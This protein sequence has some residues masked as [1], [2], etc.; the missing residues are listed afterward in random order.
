MSPYSNFHIY[1]SVENCVMNK[2]SLLHDKICALSGSAADAQTIAEIVNYQLDVHI[3]EVEDDPLVCSAATLVK[4]ISY[5][6]KEELSAHLIAWWDRKIGGQVYVTLNGLLTRQPFAIG[7]S[8][9]FYING[10]VDRESQEF[11]VNGNSNS[12]DG[13]G[14]LSGG[15]AYVVT[16]DKDGA[17]VKCILGNELAKFFDE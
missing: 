16:T 5:K 2:L 15:V 4:N 14:C 11:V 6:Y 10:F 9:R 12:G 7:G 17:E 8:G 1:S 3:I 13:S